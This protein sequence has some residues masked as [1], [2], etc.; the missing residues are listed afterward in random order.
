M[1]LQARR[2]AAL[3]SLTSRPARAALACAPFSTTP[4][5][6][7]QEVPPPWRRGLRYEI[8]DCVRGR[9]EAVC[10]RTLFVGVGL[11]AAAAYAAYTWGPKANTHSAFNAFET[12]TL[13]KTWDNDASATVPRPDLENKLRK[14]LR[15]RTTRKY[16]VIIGEHGTGKSTAVRKAVRAVGSDG[17]NGVAYYH[18]G[19]EVGQFVTGL[20]AVLDTRATVDLQGGASR[21][22]SHTTK[23]KAAPTWMDIEA[24]LISASAAFK[25]KHKRPATL[26]L[27]NVD[28]IAKNE[29]AFMIK[30][31]RFAKAMAD[32]G[33][34]RVVF[35][36]S[37]GTAPALMKEQSEWSR[38]E[39]P[40]E[41]G[42]IDDG[43]ARAY[44]EN[45]GVHADV[46][47][48]SA[49]TSSF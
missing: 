26:V 17:V 23:E 34:L 46:A 3:S 48:A 32:D 24:A 45:A 44:L 14:V 38:A 6:S 42:D 18:V 41:V 37:D 31:Q 40:T 35:V 20:A 11:I 10:K 4:Q 29:P 39:A 28:V 21:A 27:D 22:L 1:S 13:S 16:G 43:A 36:S 25:G 19:D 47:G 15:P 7:Q 9:Y 49:M 2:V 33:S 12:G 8:W 30:L 5:A